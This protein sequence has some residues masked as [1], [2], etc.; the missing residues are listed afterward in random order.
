MAA[1]GSREM[2]PIDW[3]ILPLKK[4]VRFSGRAPR[5]EYWWFYL[6]TIIVGVV[7]GL[8]G[9]LTGTGRTLADAAN[10]GLLVP[11]IAVTVRRLH[12]TDRSGWWVLALVAG[13]FVVVAIMVALGGLGA[14]TSTAGSFTSGIIV[15][16]ALLGAFLTFL[17]FMVLP[18]TEGANRYGPD[19]YGV[20][21]LEEVFA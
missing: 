4:Y 2:S 15:A 12:D 1:Y 10:L 9:K 8:V 14:A 3:A 18:G 5:A 20:D 19:P 6:G 17:A 13:V 11:W 21:D 16:L 7:L